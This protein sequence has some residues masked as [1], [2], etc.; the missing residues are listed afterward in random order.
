MVGSEPRG[1][2]E[3]GYQTFSLPYDALHTENA[4][5]V[6][7]EK[8]KIAKGIEFNYLMQLKVPL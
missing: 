3:V 7:Q 5:E 8:R 4:F 1:R 2:G 6:A